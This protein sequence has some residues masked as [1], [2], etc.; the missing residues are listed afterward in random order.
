MRVEKVPWDLTL[1]HLKLGP[2][3]SYF[4]GYLRKKYPS[5]SFWNHLSCPYHCPTPELSVTT[6][7]VLVTDTFLVGDFTQLNY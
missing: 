7:E 1:S 5:L 2:I 3:P 4:L 6:Q